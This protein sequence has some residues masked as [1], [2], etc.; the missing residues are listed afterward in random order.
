MD[1]HDEVDEN[2]CDDRRE[3]GG[4]GLIVG[5]DGFSQVDEIH[6]ERGAADD[7]AGIVVNS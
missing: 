2:D 6:H 4:L 5:S 3:E 7:D 1:D